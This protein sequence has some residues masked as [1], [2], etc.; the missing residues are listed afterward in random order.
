MS[1]KGGLFR[2]RWDTGPDL[3]LWSGGV[4]LVAAILLALLHVDVTGFFDPGRLLPDR[5]FATMVAWNPDLDYL[6]SFYVCM[7]ALL[8]PVTA[9]FLVHI[10]VRRTFLRRIETTRRLVLMLV[11]AVAMAGL[12]LLLLAYGYR[13]VDDVISTRWRA[14]L[15]LVTAHDLTIAVSFFLLFAFSALML[16]CAYG[17][18]LKLQDEPMG[19]WKGA[20]R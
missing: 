5:A 2:G 9:C 15:T 20:Q 17:F 6:A 18:V 10:H 14:H 8:L 1:R 12:P 11:T 4:Y 7:L 13:D 3:M 19:R 16:M